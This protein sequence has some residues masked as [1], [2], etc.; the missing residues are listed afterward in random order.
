MCIRD[1]DKHDQEEADRKVSWQTHESEVS[2]FIQSECMKYDIQYIG[3]QDFPDRKKPDNS[4]IIDERYVIFDA[5]SPGDSQDSASFI[6]DLNQKAK[7]QEK[8]TKMPNVKKDIYLV[9]PS[10]L[11]PDIKKRHYPLGKFEA[12]IITMEQIS[13]ILAHYKKTMDYEKFEGLSQDDKDALIRE[14][15]NLEFNLRY[16]IMVD[17]VFGKKFL[18]AIKSSKDNLPEEINDE[19]EKVI[20]DSKDN[21]SRKDSGKPLSL[22]S[23]ERE[24][25]EANLLSQSRGIPTPPIEKKSEK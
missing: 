11:Y 15:G 20:T 16:K 3:P 6:R 12:W 25:N 18:E 14:M 17:S 9:V 5:K 4:I 7:D 21:V 22:D 19:I 24:F 8:Y 10:N 1:R 23:I 13:V 2:A